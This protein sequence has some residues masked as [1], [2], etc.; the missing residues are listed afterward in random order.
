[1]PADPVASAGDALAVIAPE[2]TGGQTGVE[3][4]SPTRFVLTRQGVIREG[5]VEEQEKAWYIRLPEGKGGITISKLDTVYVGSSRQELFDWRRNQ[6]RPNDTAEILKLADWSLRNQLADAGIAMLDQVL[7]STQ[8]I[9]ARETLEKKRQEM[10]FVERIKKEA[11]ARRQDKEQK[12]ATDPREQE[13]QAL[14]QWASTIPI[15]V[16]EK[17]LRKIQPVLMRRC[18]S[19]ECHNE[20]NSVAGGLVFHR[21]LRDS[22]R[23][24]NNLKNMKAIL[25]RVD[26]ADLNKSTILIHPPIS[27]PRGQQ[28]WPFGNDSQSLADYELFRNWI[29][30]L[31]PEREKL[32]GTT[33]RNTASLPVVASPAAAAD[34][35][36]SD[37]FEPVAAEPAEG[38]LAEAAAPKSAPD[39][40][41][42]EAPAP[43]SEAGPYRPKDVYDPEVFNRMNPQNESRYKK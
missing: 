23:R 40:V 27:D 42:N 24:I 22:S 30:G 11:I 41:A 31:P 3:E 35:L 25:S 32:W 9:S 37:E 13:I 21:A 6:V 39:D 7:A 17:Y 16:Q 38:A 26:L 18:A 34:E 36:E 10:I 15:S 28:V 20:E 33:A 29:L 4:V 43:D 2:E 19:S 5:I 14:E 8:D 1:M 12:A